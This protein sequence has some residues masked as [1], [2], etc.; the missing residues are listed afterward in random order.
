[1]NITKSNINNSFGKNLKEQRSKKY[2]T[3]KEFADI[4][5]LP[6]TTYGQY[7]NG[8][9]EPDFD[10]LIK[11]AKLLDTSIDYLLIGTK[12]KDDVITVRNH[13]NECLLPGEV[14]VEDDKNRDTD[15]IM[16]KTLNGFI[17]I[18]SNICKT[19]ID[20]AKQKYEQYIN[21]S[22]KTVLNNRR[23]CLYEK[24]NIGK[25]ITE[26]TTLCKALNYDYSVIEELV[27]KSDMEFASKQAE[28]LN[29]IYWMYFTGLNTDGDIDNTLSLLGNYKRAV[30]ELRFLISIE[31]VKYQRRMW[32]SGYPDTVSD[33]TLIALDDMCD[34]ADFYPD[35]IN[36]IVE[37]FLNMH[38]GLDEEVIQEIEDPFQGRRKLF[39]EFGL[40]KINEE[41]DAP[42]LFANEAYNKCDDPEVF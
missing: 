19:I 39:F 27:E 11:I 30:K 36:P 37:L 16:I 2:K 40:M 23:D 10:L 12:R 38:W 3:Q 31:N 6:A 5:D 8:K 1:M 24:A 22:I 9:R 29:T 32:Q 7:E 21:D 18:E 4:L 26:A 35:S 13:L 14:L 33:K 25:N 34:I 42:L 41:D 15:I 20:S 28:I 17:K